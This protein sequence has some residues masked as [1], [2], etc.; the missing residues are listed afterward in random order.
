M[1]WVRSSDGA[2][3]GVCKGLARALDLPV[4][5]FRLFWLF[6]ILFFGVGLGIYVLLAMS[7][8]R[9]DKVL[10][11]LDPWIM[12]VCSRIAR[13][14]NLEVGVVRFI[15]LC[16]FFV[17]FGA[18]LVGYV[19]LYFVLDENGNQN[20]ANKPMNPPATT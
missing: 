14:C 5:L 17:S 2:L 12:G 6:S 3:F 8:P 13:R 10:K 4:G 20:S 7:L 15:A 16:L 11:S 1:K 18:S 9:E 19:V